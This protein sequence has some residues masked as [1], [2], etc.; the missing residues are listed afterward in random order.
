[1]RRRILEGAR[2]CRDLLRITGMGAAAMFLLYDCPRAAAASLIAWFVAW[3]ADRALAPWSFRP[4]SL[5]IWAG[6]LALGLIFAI[7]VLIGGVLLL[8]TLTPTML[9]LLFLIP[10][11]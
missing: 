4:L 7:P 3:V 11:R 2:A 5:A 10:S 8:A 6:S 9:L 1:M